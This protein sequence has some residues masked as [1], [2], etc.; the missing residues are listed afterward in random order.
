MTAEKSN[1]YIG[2]WTFTRQESNLFFGRDQEAQELLSLMLS[3]RLVLFYA[4]SGAGKSSLINARLVPGLE[5][6]DYFVLPIGRVGR[7]PERRPPLEKIGNIYVYNLIAYLN[8]QS[9]GK[10][11]NLTPKMSLAEYLHAYNAEDLLAEAGVEDDEYELLPQAL[12]IDQFEEIVTT[13]PEAWQAREDFF[14]QLNAAMEADPKLWVVLSLREDFLA[15]LEPY[16]YLLPGKLRARFYMQRLGEAAALEAIQGPAKEYGRPFTKR[17]AEEL[18]YRLRQI[19]TPGQKKARLGQFVEPIQLQ[20]LCHDL[21]ELIASQPGKNIT[22]KH[23]AEAGDVE[24]ALGNFYNQ[25]VLHVL[26]NHPISE[27]S[28]RIWIEKNLIIEARIRNFIYQDQEGKSTAGMENE[29]VELLAERKLLRGG[30]ARG[31][32]LV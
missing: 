5:A 1:P 26:E 25:V 2:P 8:S 24:Q 6:E 20:I 10:V 27:L 13:H 12:I 30:T 21:W 9:N 16:A 23:L 18:V 31:T 32:Q 3:Q 17:A 22:L 14:I 7:E 11:S 4:Q 15:N 28:L 19:H 29:I